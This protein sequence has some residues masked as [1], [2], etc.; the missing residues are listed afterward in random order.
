MAEGASEG[1]LVPGRANVRSACAGLTP[2]LPA[3]LPAC[4]WRGSFQ[5]E[6]ASVQGVSEPLA[7]GA[8]V[9]KTGGLDG[10][11]RRDLLVADLARACRWFPELGGFVQSRRLCC[12]EMLDGS[13]ADLLAGPND[14]ARRRAQSKAQ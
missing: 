14:D 2:C 10:R 8:G 1:L 7:E 9:V 12:I 11:R 4:L 5:S 6:L 3:C 13:R